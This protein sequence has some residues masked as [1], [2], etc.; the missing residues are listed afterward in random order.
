MGPKCPHCK[1]M[2][3]WTGWEINEVVYAPKTYC[4]ASCSKFFTVAID[5]I[6][7]IQ[8]S[9]REFYFGDG[10]APIK[11]TEADWKK[12]REDYDSGNY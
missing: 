9:A 10:E 1:Q 3:E 2:V 7:E 6:E 4:C 5:V 12:A 8:K 11:E